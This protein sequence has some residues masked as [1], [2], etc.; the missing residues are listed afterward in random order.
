MILYFTGTG[1]SRWIAERLAEATNDSI[2]NIA[3]LL[4]QDLIPE[5]VLNANVV[6]VVFPVHA[7][8]LPRKVTDF[9]LRL[10][11]LHCEYSYAVC[12]CGDDMGKGMSLLSKRFPLNAAWSVAMPNTYIPMFHLDSEK[13]SRQKIEEAQNVIPLIAQDILRRK[14]VWKVHE[15][16]A[17]WLKTFVLNPLFVRFTIS[18]RGFH[19]DEGCI[20]CGVCARSCPV[21]NIQF[22]DGHPVWGEQCIHCMACIHACPQKVVQ[23]RQKTQKKGRYKLSDYLSHL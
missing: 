13:L 19:I 1:N 20:S 6:G 10:Q 2:L 8:R 15:G 9:L 5:D 17:A 4:K 22:V 23:Y 18:H 12:T 3:D 16:G 11:F 14:K 21:E 7:W